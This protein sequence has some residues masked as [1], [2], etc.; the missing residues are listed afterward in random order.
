M[1]REKVLKGPNNLKILVYLFFIISIYLLCFN[2]S[3][4]L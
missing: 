2:I 1:G 3:V 4:V